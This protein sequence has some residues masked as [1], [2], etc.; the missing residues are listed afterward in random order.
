LKAAREVHENSLRKWNAAVKK[1][2]KRVTRLEEARFILT[3]V[4]RQ[5]QVHFQKQV[6]SLVTKAIQAVYDRPLEFKLEF[7]RKANKLQCVPKIMEGDFEFDLEF[8]KAGG[9]IDIVSF[10]FRVVL[11]SLQNPRSRPIFF[12]DEPMKFVGKGM[13]LDRAGAIL[14]QM[15]HEIGLQLIIVTHEPQLTRIADKAFRVLHDGTESEVVEIEDVTDA[16]A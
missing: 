5:T 10:A 14:R 4:T 12:L 2:K 9:L 8:D 16:E 15:S 3:E 11:W 1:K 13:L 7:I 6:E